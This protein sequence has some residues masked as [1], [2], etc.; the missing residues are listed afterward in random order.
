[1]QQPCTCWHLG[2]VH[3]GLREHHPQSRNPVP[4]M[5]ALPTKLPWGCIEVAA[6]AVPVMICLPLHR[7]LLWRRDDNI[8]YA[9]LVGG[10]ESVSTGDSVQCRIGGMLQVGDMP[11]GQQ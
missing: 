2:V 3:V 8:C 6:S 5:T 10:S 11:T 7:V 1:M 4:F 9:L